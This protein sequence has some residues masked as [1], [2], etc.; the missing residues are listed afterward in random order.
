MRHFNPLLLF[1]TEGGGAAGDATGGA[2]EAEE[3]G[4]RKSVV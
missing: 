3:T 4:D 2:A 1:D